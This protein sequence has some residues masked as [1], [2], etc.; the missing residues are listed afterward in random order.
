[1]SQCDFGAKSNARG[2]PTRRTSTLARSSRP[3][4][5]S[6]AGAFGNTMRKRSI[7]AF[8]VLE[9]RLASP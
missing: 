3:T 2:V 9:P 5:T 7:A 6:A 1:M 4:G 8:D